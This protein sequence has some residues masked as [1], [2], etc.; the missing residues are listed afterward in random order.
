M[1]ESPRHPTS[2]R[3]LAFGF[4][5]GIAAT[6][7]ITS[8]AVA[9]PVDRGS[10]TE[11]FTE[12]IE[13]FCGVEGLTI[14]VA[15][16]AKIKFM[17]NSRKPGTAPYFQQ[18][19]SA[20]AVYSNADGDFVSEKLMIAEKDLEVTDNGDGTLTILFLATGN[21][22]TYNA[23]GTAIARNPGQVRYEILIDHGQ[24]I[25]DPSDDVFLRFLGLVKESTGRSDDFCE[26]VLPILG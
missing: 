12:E 24:S 2:R 10:F 19:V 23:D 8:P 21:A 3:L 16:T 22:T 13:D 15:R 14:D 1:S 20:E 9:R 7:L 17:V 5:A 18:V 6:A 25:T 11:S 26:A 4:A